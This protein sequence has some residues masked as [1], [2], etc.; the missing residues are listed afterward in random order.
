MGA[1]PA[2][3]RVCL[4]PGGDRPEPGRS[5]FWPPGLLASFSP[6]LPQPRFLG[7]MTSGRGRGRGD[8]GPGLGDSAQES[9]VLLTFPL[10]S[11]PQGG[12]SAPAHSSRSPG[13]EQ[14]RGPTQPHA[15]VRLGTLTPCAGGAA[16]LSLTLQQCTPRLPPL[17]VCLLQCPAAC[18]RPGSLT[19][20]LLP[21]GL[22]HG[23]QGGP[24]PR[25]TPHRL[26]C[27]CSSPLRLQR[28]VWGGPITCRMQGRGLS[29]SLSRPLPCPGQGLRRLGELGPRAHSL[30]LAWG[31]PRK[32]DPSSGPGPSREDPALAWAL[33]PSWNLGAGGGS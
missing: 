16:A 4:P 8:L 5:A 20:P 12:C 30:A 6:A 23:Q 24:E 17:A 21:R 2:G 28:E 15:R 13:P 18:E 29:S 19:D 32:P 7:D 22:W 27:D 33:G 10:V 26:C 9:P 3:P 1:R 11:A 25:P 31:S 14:A